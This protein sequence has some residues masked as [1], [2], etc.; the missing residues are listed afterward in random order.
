LDKLLTTSADPNLYPEPE[1]FS[2]ERW[3]EGSIPNLH[4]FAFGI[5]GRMCIANH[6]AHKALYTAFLHLVAHFEVLPAPESA[7]DPFIIDPLEGLLDKESFVA[8]PRNYSVKL[9]PRDLARTKR[10]L[11]LP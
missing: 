4:Q 8:I 6:L 5:G 11:G 9:V 3:L 1:K 7:E 10:M 2:P